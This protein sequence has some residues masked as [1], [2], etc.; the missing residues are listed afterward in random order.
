M[1]EAVFENT[2]LKHQVFAEIEGHIDPDAVLGSN[3]SSLPITGLATGVTRP[4]NFVGIHFF[5]PVIKM[6]PVEVI[7]GEQTSDE[8]LAK[9]ID[10]VLAIGKY[11]IVVNDGR[12]FFTTRVFATFLTEAIKMLHEGIDPAVI[13]Q[14]ALQAGYPAGPLQ[15]ADELSFGTM[16]KIMDETLPAADR[17]GTPAS[18]AADGPRMTRRAPN[19]RGR[20]GTSLRVRTADTPARSQP[21]SWRGTGWSHPGNPARYPR[22]AS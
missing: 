4:E 8:A 11:P 5:S 6:D 12:G 1:V 19:V 14:A 17:D 20:H 15:L 7:R 3:T 18:E 2:E 9:A 16:R 21:T 10:F 13:E 22:S